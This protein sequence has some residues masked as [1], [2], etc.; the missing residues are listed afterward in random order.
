MSKYEWMFD[1]LNGY[2]DMLYGSGSLS[3][4]EEEEMNELNDDII[5]L[6]RSQEVRIE[7]LEKEVAAARIKGAEELAAKALEI[8]GA[9]IGPQVRKLLEDYKNQSDKALYEECANCAF[10]HRHCDGVAGRKFCVDF[11]EGE[12]K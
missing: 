9:W 4:D 1:K 12:E 7:Q 8:Y 6:I 3:E 10:D 5:H 2:L 11:E